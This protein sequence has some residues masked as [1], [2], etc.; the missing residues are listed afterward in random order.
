MAKDAS[1]EID[2]GFVTGA[3]AALFIFIV[4]AISYGAGKAA[5]QREEAAR[6]LM[7]RKI[8]LADDAADR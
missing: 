7:E 3:V 5:A 2:L 6:N 1:V 4:G 8:G